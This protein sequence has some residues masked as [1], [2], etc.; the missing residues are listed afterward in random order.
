MPIL[1]KFG[2]RIHVTRATPSGGK[3]RLTEALVREQA[4]LSEQLALLDYYTAQ[5]NHYYDGAFGWLG[6]GP[7]GGWPADRKQDRTHAP[8]PQLTEDA[9]FTHLALARDLASR[10]GGAI[11]MRDH[12]AAFIGSVGVQF[13]S[14]GNAPGAAAS[15]P[16]DADGDGE[17]D[18]TPAVKAATEC[19]E[20]WCEAADWG[21]GE[22][23]RERECL[24]RSVTEGEC[25]LEFFRGPPREVPTCR[26]VEPELIRSP[27]VLPD[28]FGWAEPEDWRWGIL[29]RPSDAETMLALYVA[30]AEGPGGRV[31]PANRF[32]RTK[33][34]VDRSVKRGLSDFFPVAVLIRKVLDLEETIAHVARIQAAIPWWEQFSTATQAQVLAMA[35]SMRNPI[36]AGI[37]AGM[38]GGQPPSALFPPTQQEYYPAGS[39]PRTEGGRSVLPGPV[40]NSGPLI[41]VIR[42]GM[43][44]VAWRFGFPAS[45]ADGVGDSFAGELVSGSRFARV[46]EARQKK[47][48]GWTRAIVMMVLRLS[49]ES[50]RIPPGTTDAVKP[51]LTSPPV[52]IADEEKQARTFLALYDKGLADP[53]AWLK[54]HGEDPK[55][56]MANLADHK[57]KM[58]AM[59]PKPEPR[60]DTPPGP[61]DPSATPPGSAGGVQSSPNRPA[62]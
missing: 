56:V 45:F 34:N 11:G 48:Q 32:V 30:D 62:D 37:P 10:N 16:V 51:V 55:I 1:P 9:Y 27:D 19:W 31:V 38:G 12:I 59:Q 15:G 41:E 2:S 5:Y 40:T 20:E 28:S 36:P 50:G 7:W 53:W 33:G 3:Q 44:A 24:N 60:A 39:I 14:Q 52:E 42:M 57:K 13:V 43:R 25:T 29:T 4:R 54:A 49:E 61:R 17:P 58:A 21:M 22:T 46:I 8:L 47:Q 6:G 26:H 23:D 35:E 18:V